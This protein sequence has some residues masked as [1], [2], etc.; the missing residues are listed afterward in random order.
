MKV[1]LIK[2]YRRSKFKWKDKQRCF[3][4]TWQQRNIWMKQR[5]M[6][7]HKFTLSSKWKLKIQVKTSYFWDNSENTINKWVITHE[8]LNHENQ[9]MALTRKHIHAR[10]LQINGSWSRCLELLPQPLTLHS[11]CY[12]IIWWHTKT[13]HWVGFSELSFSGYHFKLRKFELQK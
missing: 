8:I 3:P 12:Y 11:H 2:V 1:T 13:V 6:E 5:Q 4:G 9:I 7:C 10:A